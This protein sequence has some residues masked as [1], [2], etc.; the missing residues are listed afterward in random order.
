[1][2]DRFKVSVVVP[3]YNTAEYLPECLD[4]LVGQSIGLDSIQIVVVDDGSTDNSAAVIKSY[5]ER[6]PGNFVC[7]EQPNSGQGVARN[8]ALAHCEGEYVGFMDS[9]DFADKDMY[10]LLYEAARAADAD[11][12]VC[13]MV[14]F[15]DR[16]GVREYSRNP[17]QPASPMTQESLFVAPQVQPP[18]R[19][20][21]RSVL[22]DNGVR[23]PET[24]GN[25]DS[26]FHL[27]SAPF[28]DTI[29]SVNLPLVNRRLR[30]GSTVVSVSSYLCEQFFSVVDDIFEFYEERGLLH[31]YGELLE[32]GL[33]R[34]LLCSRL[35]CIGCVDDRRQREL[36]TSKTAEFL[37]TRFPNRAKNRYLPGALGI[38]L[39]YAGPLMMRAARG[40]FAARYRRKF[41]FVGC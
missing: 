19:V 18:I 10:R 25:E 14:S 5:A 3:V 9:D 34:M 20:V 24:R 30:S 13:G 38:Y 6:C 4:S 29:V 7:L 15:C 21:R 39:R 8:L 37:D 27:K 40:P 23:F 22:V 2:N 41:M 17:Q 31:D 35:G 1:M 28:C 11:M 16:D 12:C 36:L 26:G 32:A 33:V